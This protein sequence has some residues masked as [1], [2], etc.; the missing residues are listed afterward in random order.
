MEWEEWLSEVVLSVA[1]VPL[2]I[3]CETHEKMMLISLVEFT[4]RCLNKVRP[5]CVMLVYNC[6]LDP[7]ILMMH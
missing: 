2:F 1:S 6:S 4:I 3:A 7:F 5:W